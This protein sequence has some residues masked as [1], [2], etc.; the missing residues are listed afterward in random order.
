MKLEDPTATSPGPAGMCVLSPQP[1]MDNEAAS[2][3]EASP[4]RK[5]FMDMPL[6]EIGVA[7]KVAA[8]SKELG[9]TGSPE[10]SRS[11]ELPNP[12]H[13][14]VFVLDDVAVVDGAPR[15]SPHR[16]GRRD[17]LETLHEGARSHSGIV[18]NSRRNI[19]A[20][21]FSYASQL[22]PQSSM[23]MRTNAAL[24]VAKKTS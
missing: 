6:N 24:C 16:N 13:A 5:S 23:R 1:T 9:A 4:Y 10:G 17:T 15:E 20:V 21:H 8:P 14:D 12:H 11:C 3:S 18:V 22:Q 2:V 19:A 7:S